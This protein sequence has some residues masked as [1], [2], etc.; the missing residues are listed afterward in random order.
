MNITTEKRAGNRWN[1]NEILMLQRE[2]ELLEMSIQEIALR[3]QRSVDSILF[4]LERE[5]FIENWNVARGIKEFDNTCPCDDDEDE[6]DDDEDD[7]EDEDDVSDV[8][9]LS[10]RV[11]N[12]E[13]SVSDIKGMVKNMFDTLVQQKNK[14]LAPLRNTTH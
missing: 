4:K 1:I 9:K 8:D 11:W 14:K 7:D 3:H 2:Y 13:T 5:G 12:L 10:E 6:D